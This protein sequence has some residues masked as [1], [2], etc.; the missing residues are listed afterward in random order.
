MSLCSAAL[1][2]AGIIVPIVQMVVYSLRYQ[3]FL[4]AALI[5]LG[6]V[7]LKLLPFI[8]EDVH[9]SPSSELQAM[10]MLKLAD[11]SESLAS[12]SESGTDD[13]FFM[14]SVSAASGASSSS[15]YCSLY[16]QTSPSKHANCKMVFLGK[17]SRDLISD[18][19]PAHMDDQLDI[20]ADAI[21]SIEQVVH[22]QKGVG[23]ADAKDAITG[24]P[25]HYWTDM[26]ISLMVLFIVG[27]GTTFSIYLETYVDQTLVVNPHYKA[28]V[29]MMLF[30][31]GTIAYSYR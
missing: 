19:D 30:C 17:S 14:T 10:S 31:S 15:L 13:A 8:P 12:M 6:G 1:V 28:M 9:G 25:P 24:E 20:E 21:D 11:S 7:W 22:V 27:A 16:G 2:S 29:L 5:A 4:Y 3:F 26:F 23:V 18:A